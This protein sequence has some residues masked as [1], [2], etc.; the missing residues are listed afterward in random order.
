VARES[1]SPLSRIVPPAMLPAED[2]SP[3]TTSWP[4]VR[5][6]RA[7]ISLALVIALIVIAVQVHGSIEENLSA[8]E[9]TQLYTEA[10]LH[11]VVAVGI[12]FGLYK[13]TD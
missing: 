4:D 11:A 2:D 12:A 1:P 8:P 5:I 7:I 6:F 9:V 13:L 10:I 3:R